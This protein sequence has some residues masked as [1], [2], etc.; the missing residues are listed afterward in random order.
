MTASN[1]AKIRALLIAA[2]DEATEHLE[3]PDNS[4]FTSTGMISHLAEHLT[5]IIDKMAPAPALVRVGYP[6]RVLPDPSDSARTGG[7][8]YWQGST[9]LVMRTGFGGWA[10]EDQPLNRTWKVRIETT[11]HEGALPADRI[12]QV[13]EDFLQVIGE[14]SQDNADPY[15]CGGCHGRGQT[16]LAPLSPCMRCA[17]TGIDPYVRP[18]PELDSAD[19]ICGYSPAHGAQN[20]RAVTTIDCGPV[21]IVPAC[22][23]CA[24]FYGQMNPRMA[25]RSEADQL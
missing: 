7:P 24:D 17:G 15:P 12:I 22:Q 20:I 11:D 10:G 14:V 18:Q 9:G 21:G 8:N 4:R 3:D 19:V 2:R 16:A 25:V 6:V 5:A 13:R 1:Y 23:K